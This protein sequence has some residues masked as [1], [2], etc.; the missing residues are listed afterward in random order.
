MGAIVR[1]L[2]QLTANLT[3]EK[4]AQEA[5]DYFRDITPR[6][7]GNARSKTRRVNNEIRADYPYAQRLDNGYSPQAPSG[8]T[9]PTIKYIQ[10]YIKQQGDR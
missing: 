4:L 6:R 7:T 10:E 8:M 1:R 3:D 9:E 5:Y 2:D